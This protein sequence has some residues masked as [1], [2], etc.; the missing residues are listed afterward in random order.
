[1]IRSPRSFSITA[2][3]TFSLLICSPVMAGDWPGWLGPNQ[4]GSSPEKGVFGKGK[5]AT[6]LSVTWNRELGKAYSGIAVVDGKA[7]TMFGDG[8]TDWLIAMD[9]DSGEELWRYR[10]DEMFPKIGG[11]DGGQLGM[12]VVDGGTIYGLGAAGQ[13]FAVRLDDGSEIWTV[14]IEEQLGAKRPYFGFTTTP[15][16]VGNLLFV[17]TGGDEGNGLTAVSKKNGERKW[18]VGD[19]PVGYQS[20]ILTE[21]AGVRQIVAVTNTSVTGLTADGEVLWRQEHGLVDRRD[22]WATPILTGENSFVLTGGAE[23][24]A[25]RVKRGGDGFDVKELWRA[26]SLKGNFA[27]PVV[28]GGHLYGYDGD[29]LACVN[30]ATGERKWK[31]RNDAAGLILVDDRL[32]IFSSDGAVVVAEASTAGFEEQARVQVDE[33]AGFTYPSFSD[34]GIYVRNL[35]HIARVDIVKN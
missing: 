14:D 20:P 22:G 21:L 10:I 13:L 3:L 26:N 2:A 8:Q 11:A 6:S 18:A 31:H 15:L 25:Y 29:F 9:T 34:G 1:M 19:E 12:P 33:E 30:A 4:D 5:A 35:K 23:S 17:Q 24:V 27:M 16:V 7:V 28:H 32:V